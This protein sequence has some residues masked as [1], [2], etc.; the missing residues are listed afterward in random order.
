MPD[1]NELNDHLSFPGMKQKVSLNSPGNQDKSTGLSGIS[2][3]KEFSTGQASQTG[4]MAAVN[5]E[6]ANNFVS[7][8]PGRE[9]GIVSPAFV[10]SSKLTGSFMVAGFDTN[11]DR[12]KEESGKINIP[13]PGIENQ[14]DNVPFK[15]ENNEIIS[16]HG[17]AEKK[18]STDSD[19]K[20][21]R[22]AAKRADRKNEE[23]LQ[24]YSVNKK[25]QTN[26]TN[27]SISHN[28]KINKLL[29]DDNQQLNTEYRGIPEGEEIPANNLPET[30]NLTPDPRPGTSIQDINT[31]V[32]LHN[33]SNSNKYPAEN[34]FEAPESSEKP[35]LATTPVDY[36]SISKN[37]I[38]QHAFRFEK[39]EV[40]GFSGIISNQE[41]DA[42]GKQKTDIAPVKPSLFVREETVKPQ[43]KLT[44]GKLTVE[45]IQ[46]SKEKTPPAQ[47]KERI[48]QQKALPGFRGSGGS[49]LKVKFGLG[50]L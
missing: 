24:K 4:S 11:P 15:V 27:V 45:V 17:K 16:F 48:I 46:P 20:E 14:P 31:M 32:D 22:H 5:E 34:N 42:S 6:I 29:S 28:T 43:T 33:S 7:G 21:S 9:S 49:G 41:T 19:L 50:Q 30:R 37:K 36:Y 3:F 2:G 8:I 44:I 23:N 38:T 47:F 40:S 18:D 10:H 39:K 1:K 13:P 25:E 12:W 26:D 35:D